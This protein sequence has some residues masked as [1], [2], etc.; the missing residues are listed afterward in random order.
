MDAVV[1]MLLFPN[2]WPF[3]TS[4]SVLDD[5]I[6]GKRKQVSQ[7]KP[8]EEHDNGQGVDASSFPEKLKIE[9]GEHK[10]SAY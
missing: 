5:P 8:V 1:K 10:S 7:P 2:I 3:F 6:F 4:G 9:N